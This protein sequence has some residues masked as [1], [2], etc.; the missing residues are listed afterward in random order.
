MVTTGSAEIA[1]LI[2]SLFIKLNFSIIFIV[3]YFITRVKNE[4]E[5]HRTNITLTY[6]MT[7]KQFMIAYS[8]FAELLILCSIA[9]SFLFFYVCLQASI[10]YVCKIFFLVEI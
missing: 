6:G 5:K 8:V 7:T 9:R 2:L 1:V 10:K 3:N 4:E